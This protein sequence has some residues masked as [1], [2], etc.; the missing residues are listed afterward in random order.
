MEG[1]EDRGENILR[2]QVS[3]K[4]QVLF[5][6]EWTVQSTDEKMQGLLYEI[7]EKA[8]EYMEFLLW[9]KFRDRL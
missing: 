2:F 7:G 4:G 1:R 6:P 9:K 8:A 5:R 3:S